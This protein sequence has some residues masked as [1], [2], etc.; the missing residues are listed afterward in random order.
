MTNEV[1]VKYL[2]PVPGLNPQDLAELGALQAT[3]GMS[4]PETRAFI[5]KVQQMAAQTALA[6]APDLLES[7]RQVQEKRFLS[8]YTQIRLLPQYMGY[9]SRDR[10]LA[11]LQSVAAQT[12][13]K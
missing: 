7:V 1:E 8:I 3:N 2:D 6:M 9:V 12:P 4:V 13:P 11:I 10:V 5:A